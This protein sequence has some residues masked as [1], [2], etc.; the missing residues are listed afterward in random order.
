MKPISLPIKNLKEFKEIDKLRIKF[1]LALIDALIFFHA[2]T[3]KGY[4]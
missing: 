1:G 2:K 3:E 4:L